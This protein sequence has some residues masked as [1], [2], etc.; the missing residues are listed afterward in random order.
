MKS[1]SLPARSKHWAEC[2]ELARKAV[3]VRQKNPATGNFIAHFQAVPG[4]DYCLSSMTLALPDDQ[5]LRFSFYRLATIG[6]ANPLLRQTLAL[7]GNDI[8]QEIL[9]DLSPVVFLDSFGITYLAACLDRCRD[10]K[11]ITKILIRPPTLSNVHR[12]LQEV[13]FYE[14]IGLGNQ[15][16]ARQ[17]NKNRVDLIHIQTLEPLFIDGLLD[18]LESTQP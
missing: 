5:P 1:F 8:S 11:A 7:L 17:P 10:Q 12:H 9:V 4:L 2:S 15:F 14:S 18:F 13:G 3:R 16:Q 6:W